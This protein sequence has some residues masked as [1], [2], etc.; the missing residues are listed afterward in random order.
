MPPPFQTISVGLPAADRAAKYRNYRERNLAM[1]ASTE[2][3]TQLTRMLT[4][5]QAA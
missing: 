3:R 1:D 5:R 4:E 2:L